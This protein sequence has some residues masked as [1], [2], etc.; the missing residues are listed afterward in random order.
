MADYLIHDST[1]EDIADA[2]RA[3]TGKSATMTPLEMP[4]EIAS[5]ETGGGGSSLP[6][7]ISVIDGGSFTFASDTQASRYTITHN[8]GTKPK[9]I[10]LWTE[11]STLLESSEATSE[12]YIIWSSYMLLSWVHSATTTYTGFPFYVY[13]NTTGTSSNTGAP[14][15]ATSSVTNS[16]FLLPSTMFYKSGIEYKWVAFA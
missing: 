5:I 9:Q 14:S 3:K 8:L 1:L 7:T 6:S 13:R 15:T 16:D 10:V 12:R 11:D 2:I 4:S